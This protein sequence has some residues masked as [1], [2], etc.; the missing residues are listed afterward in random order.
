MLFRSYMLLV[1][2]TDIRQLLPTTYKLLLFTD[3]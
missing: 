2:L 1:L 3:H